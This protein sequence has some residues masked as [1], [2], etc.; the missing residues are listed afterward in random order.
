VRARL[1]QR[2]TEAVQEIG[3]LRQFELRARA[4]EGALEKREEELAATRRELALLL[5]GAAAARP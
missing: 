2:L 1:E 5:S 3:T 4:L